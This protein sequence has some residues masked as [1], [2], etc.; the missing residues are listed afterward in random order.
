MFSVF[1]SAA[2]FGDCAAFPLSCGPFL[3]PFSFYV[4]LSQTASNPVLEVCSMQK[5]KKIIAFIKH[6]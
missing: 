5:K 2:A 4:S 3:F 1:T 6:L